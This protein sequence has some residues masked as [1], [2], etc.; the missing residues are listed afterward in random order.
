MKVYH[1]TP[2]MRKLIVLAKQFLPD[3]VTV[4]HL[5]VVSFLLV[6]KVYFLLE[7]YIND[8]YSSNTHLKVWWFNITIISDNGTRRGCGS[9]KLEIL[10]SFS[11]FPH[12]K[13]KFLFLRFLALW[14]NLDEHFSSY[15]VKISAISRTADSDLNIQAT[16]LKIENPLIPSTGIPIKFKKILKLLILQ[17]LRYIFQPVKS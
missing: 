9:R 6:W 17:F 2:N 3:V 11:I 5:P 13:E 8:P 15:P 4:H 1:E 14:F 16:Q 10:F 7:E 12:Y